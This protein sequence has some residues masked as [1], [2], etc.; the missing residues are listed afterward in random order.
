M[1]KPATSTPRVAPTLI[2]AP[3]RLRLSSGNHLYIE[4]MATGADGPSAS[5]SSTRAITMITSD[6]VAAIGTWTTD[7]AMAM[8]SISQRVWIR[9]ARKP[10]ATPPTANSQKTLPATPPNC[11]GVRP[12]SAIIGIATRPT[13]TLSTK[14]TN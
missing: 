13:T 10:P 9:L 5:P 11:T 3:G 14:F 4:C 12:R 8:T 7:Q 1:P 6:E 2:S